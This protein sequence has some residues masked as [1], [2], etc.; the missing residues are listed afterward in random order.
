MNPPP[1]LHYHPFSV[2]ILHILVLRWVLATGRKQNT[3]KAGAIVPESCCT[4]HQL[5]IHGSRQL[6]HRGPDNVF[7]SPFFCHQR[8]SERA[9]R[10]ALEKQLDPRGPIASRRGSVQEFIRKSI[11]TCYYPVGGPDPL[12]HPRWIR[13]RWIDSVKLSLLISNC[14]GYFSISWKLRVRNSCRMEFAERIP[15]HSIKRWYCVFTGVLG[16]D[17]MQN[18]A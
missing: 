4:F 17:W 6:R 8:I 7:F 10:T 5:N 16:T 11:A 2:N 1:P 12:P 15:V 13:P 3:V 18:S 9:V 14:V